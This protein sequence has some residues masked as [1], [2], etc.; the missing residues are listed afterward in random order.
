MTDLPEFLLR[1]L[2]GVLFQ[3]SLPQSFLNS[4]AGLSNNSVLTEIFQ[5]T[6][7]A[8]NL[9]PMNTQT[10]LLKYRFAQP[11]F[12]RRIHLNLL[13]LYQSKYNEFLNQIYH[14]YTL[15]ELQQLTELG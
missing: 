2:L 4:L 6:V 8:D 9:L 11:I 12:L 7:T 10:E 14:I 15:E 3:P 5:A 1:K 13:K